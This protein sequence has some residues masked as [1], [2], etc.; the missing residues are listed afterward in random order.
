MSASSQILTLSTNGGLFQPP[1]TRKTNGATTTS[2]QNRTHAQCARVLTPAALS[3]Q[4]INACTTDPTI[5][6]KDFTDPQ[7]YK[8][9][10]DDTHEEVIR[11]SEAAADGN[12]AV[13]QSSKTVDNDLLALD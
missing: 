2:P 8:Q 1:A 6:V 11:A 9:A 12:I 13:T 5:E 7:E 10:Y 3:L 4:K